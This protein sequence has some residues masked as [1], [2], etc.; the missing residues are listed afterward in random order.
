[1]PQLVQCPF[2][3]QMMSVPDVLIG[4][5]VS[6]PT[7]KKVFLVPAQVPARE[8]VAAAVSAP[9][10]APST[11]S[12]PT[13]PRPAPPPPSAPRTPAAPNVC[14]A[15]K[16]PLLPGAIACMDCGYLIQ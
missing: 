4:K 8:P 14:P 3:P 10:S 5:Q 2:C 9:P 16:S 7:C 1:M 6:C 13:P 11:P 12:R 15:C